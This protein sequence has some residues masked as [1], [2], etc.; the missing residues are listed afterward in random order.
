MPIFYRLATLIFTTIM[1]ATSVAAPVSVT[2]RAEIE[3]LLSRL[4]SSGCEF[5]RNGTW[6]S[7]A[8]A[9][10]HLLRKLKYFEGKNNIQSTEQFIQLAASSSSASGALYLVKCGSTAELPSQQWL[11]IELTD[12]R[13]ATKSDKP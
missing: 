2:T 7:G 8:E 10:T 1:C 5:N 12:I 6:Y 3:A 9:R 11:T 4:Q 13:A